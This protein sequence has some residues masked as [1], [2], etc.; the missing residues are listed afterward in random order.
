MT[1]TAPETARLFDTRNSQAAGRSAPGV[2]KSE[3]FDFQLMRWLSQ[4]P[5]SGSEIGE[6]YATAHLIEDGN[7]ESWLQEWQKTARR[8]EAVARECLTRGHRVSA[9]EAFLRATTYYEAAFFYT[10]EHDTRKRQLYDHHRE[11]FRAAGALMDTP[12]EAVRIPYEGRTL[13]GYFLRP[14]DTG[15]RRATVLIMTGGDGTAERLYF[16]SGGAAGLRR[17]YNILLFEGPGQSGAYMLDNTLVFR[18]DYEVPVA[19]IVDYA[20][21]RPEVD[22]DRIAL[23]GYSMGGYFAPRA[24]AFE[25]RIAACV[26]D[27]L[28]P[29]AYTP[30]SRT[31]EMDELITSGA[32]VHLE[33]LTQ[34]QRYSVEEGMP[35]FGFDHGVEDIPKWGEE[36]K[37]MNLTGLE[38]RITCPLL[39][40]SSTGEGELM[41][42]NARTF[43]GALPNPL[44]RFVLTNEEQGAEMHCQRG[45]SSLLHQLEFDWLDEVL[46]NE[47]S[48]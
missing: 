31:M 11:C 18:H 40:L 46:A 43:F 12:F 36:L 38:H 15:A 47:Y 44:N 3:T 48:V 42:K 1:T 28:M 35:R 14:D 30:M 2:F 32:P 13:P 37:K 19:A 27:C 4:A 6:C 26:A 34:K 39:N 16:N 23:I 25:K 20:V 21:S 33:D 10:A 22:T 9:R 7:N 45:N 8:V 5:Y 17:G 29:D 24:A 41:Y